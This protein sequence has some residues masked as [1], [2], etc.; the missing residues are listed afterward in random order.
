[1][2]SLI[3]TPA[4]LSTILAALRYYQMHL[5]CNGEVPPRPVGEIATNCG[6]HEPLTSGMIDQLCETINR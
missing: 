2:K 6:Q 1:M 3:V 5:E 4:Q